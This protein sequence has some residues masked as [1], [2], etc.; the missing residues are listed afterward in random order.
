[1]GRFQAAKAVKAVNA[2]KAAK[3]AKAAKGLPMHTSYY[4]YQSLLS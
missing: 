1:M 2:V 3:A 4:I